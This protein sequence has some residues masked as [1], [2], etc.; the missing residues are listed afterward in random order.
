VPTNAGREFYPQTFIP[1]PAATRRDAFI[2]DWCLRLQVVG[3]AH[4]RQKFLKIFL[5]KIKS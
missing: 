3:A 1:R 5:K 2:P 4:P